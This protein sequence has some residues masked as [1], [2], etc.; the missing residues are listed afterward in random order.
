MIRYVHSKVLN[1]TTMLTHKQ[2]F[3]AACSGM[4][5]GMYGTF[6]HVEY[7]SDIRTSS[8][9]MGEFEDRYRTTKQESA[10]LESERVFCVSQSEYCVEDRSRET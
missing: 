9:T 1:D 4:W 6:G 7:A 8:T 3:Y 2:M 10:G 5:D